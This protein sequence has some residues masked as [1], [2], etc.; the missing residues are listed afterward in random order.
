MTHQSEVAMMAHEEGIGWTS[1]D[2]SV[3]GAPLSAA[4]RLRRGPLVFG[5]AL[6]ATA[7]IAALL[8]SRRV[9]REAVT[10]VSASIQDS[11]IDG[12]CADA[13]KQCG[14]VKFSGN[15]C[16]KLGCTCE[17]QSDYFHGCKPSGGMDHCSIKAGSGDFERDS[18]K[19]AKDLVLKSKAAHDAYEKAA[20]AE[21]Q[22][23]IK[24]HASLVASQAA[25][26][27]VN[28]EDKDGFA[29]ALGKQIKAAKDAK[30]AGMHASSVART[31]LG[32]N[33]HRVK[34]SK[35]LL[36]W[37]DK[38]EEMQKRLGGTG[39]EEQSSSSSS[40]STDSDDSD[41]GAASAQMQAEVE[42]LKKELEKMQ[43]HE[44]AASSDTSS[45]SDDDTSSAEDD[46][47][48]GD[49]TFQVISAE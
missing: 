19:L 38:A 48:S 4:R 39:A 32:V 11:S 25:L 37:L 40:S 21:E 2:E 5:T 42:Q 46:D 15:K 22:T 31:A 9:T 7:V 23:L 28:A 47:D 44:D 1:S 20:E 18:I 36:S 3:N 45:A 12:N 13:F 43:Q 41:S 33:A 6:L 49:A 26:K 30:L 8:V 10:D 34:V 17:P 29:A 27:T 24:A 35:K 14:G 16:C